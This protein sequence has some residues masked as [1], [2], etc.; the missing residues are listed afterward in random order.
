[1]KQSEY[2]NIK[3]H[4]ELH[5]ELKMQA[6]KEGVSLFALVENACRR[7]L[8]KKTEKGKK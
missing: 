4:P 3:I 8:G 6:V 7:Y 5:T 2:K 1:M